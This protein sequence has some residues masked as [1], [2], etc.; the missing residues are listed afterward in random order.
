SSRCK[1]LATSLV[2]ANLSYPRCCNG[3]LESLHSLHGCSWL[4][5]IFCQNAHLYQIVLQR[6]LPSWLLPV[7][8]RLG[9]QRLLSATVQE[10]QHRERRQDRE[11]DD[12]D[13]EPRHV[14]IEP[15]HIAGKRVAEEDGPGHVVVGVG[16]PGPAADR[17]IA[18]N[19]CS[20]E[21]RVPGHGPAAD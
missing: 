1:G 14:L 16:G 12:P 20:A 9:R 11:R 4:S 6:R 7:V 2:A 5:S 19:G 13:H 15:V 21:G 10:R 3:R 18:G 8:V 17:E